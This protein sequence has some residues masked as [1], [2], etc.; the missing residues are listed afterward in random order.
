MAH[1]QQLCGAKQAA[2]MI[3]SIWRQ[4]RQSNFLAA[5]LRSFLSQLLSAYAASSRDQKVNF[6]EICSCR[7]LNIVLGVPNKALGAGATP[8]LAYAPL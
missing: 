4:L 6:A 8:K 2:H 1:L 3:G 5:D 7:G